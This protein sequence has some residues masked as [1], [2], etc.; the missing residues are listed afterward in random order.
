MEKEITAAKT[1]GLIIEATKAVLG[2]ATEILGEEE[3]KKLA[4]T[5]TKGGIIGL[6]VGVGLITVATILKGVAGK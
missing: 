5:M 4:E 3:T 6:A 1:G 2:K